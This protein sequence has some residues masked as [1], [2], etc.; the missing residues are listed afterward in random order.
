MSWF[1]RSLNEFAGA[2]LTGLGLENTE[3]NR[4]VFLVILGVLACAVSDSLFGWASRLWQPK[5]PSE[6][7][8]A[9]LDRLKVPDKW[10]ASTYAVSEKGSVDYLY[11]DMIR[12]VTIKIGD[13]HIE[14][15]LTFRERC[16]IRR[17]SSALHQQLI[18][19]QRRAVVNRAIARLQ[20]P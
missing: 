6:L 18:S 14:R 20:R 9:I 19:D 10:T 4:A 12:P 1:Q 13:A 3:G 15:E 17:A 11:I 5:E 16:A 2:S 7:A 8:K